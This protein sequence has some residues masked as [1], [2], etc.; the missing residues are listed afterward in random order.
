M[1]IRFPRLPQIRFLRRPHL[2]GQAEHGTAAGPVPGIL[3]VPRGVALALIAT[4]VA[5]ASLVSF[6]ESYRGLYLWAQRHG[7]S[8]F[9]AAIWPLQ[10]DVFIAVGE[11]AL[12][13]ALVDRWA[14]RSRTAAWAVTLTGLAVSVAG[15]VGHVTGHSL[16]V[17]ATAAV[18][19]VAAASALAV[20]LGVLK[21]VV[22]QHYQPARDLA[23]LPETTRQDRPASA[24]QAAP[25][26]AP[27][28]LPRTTAKVLPET[29][30]EVTPHP[31]LEAVPD[32][33]DRSPVASE[34]Q[35]GPVT[36][37]RLAE[38]YAADLAAGRV[39]S[40]RQIKREW[41]VGFDAASELHE[42]LAARAAP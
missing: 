29:A 10:V 4:L 13:V 26:T 32:L 41:P 25:G 35:A 8:G 42:Q 39:P 27:E 33:Q 5:A 11:L 17:R 12:F 30:P 6:A 16:A 1:K 15:N 14:P 7:L 34:K 28:V 19:P 38:Y 18:P 2:Q 31:A 20:G 22:E 36:P 3:R 24:A 23:A 37:E 40:K 21:R 9:W